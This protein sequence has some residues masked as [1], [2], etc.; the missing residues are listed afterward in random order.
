MF[1][2]FQ[3]SFQV[4]VV[5]RSF[6]SCPFD[7]LKFVSQRETL[8]QNTILGK[9]EKNRRISPSLSF[10]LPF[11]THPSAIRERKEKKICLV[12]S[13][14]QKFLPTKKNFAAEK[15]NSLGEEEY[16]VSSSSSPLSS[17]LEK[18]SPHEISRNLERRGRRAAKRRWPA[19]RT[20][21][22][23]ENT[24]RKGR[25]ALACVF[26]RVVAAAAL[27]G[28]A[29]QRGRVGAARA[30]FPTSAAA[31]ALARNPG[32]LAAAA[33]ATALHPFAPA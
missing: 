10:S 18:T 23:R 15:N 19:R 29:I 6:F 24:V 22:R 28:V 32:P 26:V 27:R 1:R 30:A 16:F 8:S 3:P 4:Q 14:L 13:S 31:L 5:E 21:R 12:L 25:R 7:I 2:T 17:F 9:R 33:A 20:H 11:E